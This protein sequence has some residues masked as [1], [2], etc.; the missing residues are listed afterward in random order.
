M[1]KIHNGKRYDTETAE[2]VAQYCN[3][4]S[5]RDFYN[6][7]EELYRTKA[8]AWFL[9]GEG[10]AAT[11]YKEPVD[12][13]CWQGG[14]DIVPLTA[15]EAQEWLEQHDMTASLEKYFGDKIQDA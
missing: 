10:G 1:K 4:L 12:N 6:L 3:G 5:S 2:I 15:I 13:N 7:S 9:F 14:S 8:G 11:K